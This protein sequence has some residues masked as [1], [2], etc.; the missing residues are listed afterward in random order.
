MNRLITE[1]MNFS[2][3]AFDNF[4]ICTGINHRMCKTTLFKVQ[5]KQTHEQRGG[6]NMLNSGVTNTA[7]N[8]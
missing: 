1:A 2:S 3:L 8:I 5:I 4:R 6:K 7:V